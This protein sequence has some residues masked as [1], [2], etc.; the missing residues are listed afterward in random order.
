MEGISKVGL[1][2]EIGLKGKVEV[3]EDEGGNEGVNRV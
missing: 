3:D 1:L 2:V